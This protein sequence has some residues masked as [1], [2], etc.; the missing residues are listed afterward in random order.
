M[1]G[2]TSPTVECN[3]MRYEGERSEWFTLAV[4]K[5][6]EESP[7]FVGPKYKMKGHS[8]LFRSRWFLIVHD[9]A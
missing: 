9:D 7:L 5:I 1:T 3:G 4:Q 8:F 2:L 6:S